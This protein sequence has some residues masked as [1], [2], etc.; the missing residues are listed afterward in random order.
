MNPRGDIDDRSATAVGLRRDAG[1]DDADLP[2]TQ[3]ARALGLQ[4][5][6]ADGLAELDGVRSSEPEI[7]VRILL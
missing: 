4:D 2:R 1:P 5:R 7:A 6:F 3:V